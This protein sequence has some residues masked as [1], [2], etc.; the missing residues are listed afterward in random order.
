M[1][2]GRKGEAATRAEAPAVATRPAAS[3]GLPGAALSQRMPTRAVPPTKQVPHTKGDPVA[4][5]TDDSAP[6]AP[7]T[8]IE[9]A[10]GGGESSRHT[11]TANAETSTTPPAGRRG[12]AGLRVGGDRVPA[13]LAAPGRRLDPGDR[14]LRGAVVGGAGH[15]VPLGVGDLLRRWHCP[16]RH[17]LAE[18]RTR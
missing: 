7:I 11:V 17:P 14:R 13:A 6:Q 5:A 8:R 4:S 10:S 18:R 16:G 2:T 3:V 1:S 15:R 12:G 9:P